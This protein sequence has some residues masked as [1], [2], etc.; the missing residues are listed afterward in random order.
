MPIVAQ[1]KPTRQS[2]KLVTGVFAFPTTVLGM[3]RNYS[4]VD[5]VDVR[6]CV[7]HPVVGKAN[8]RHCEFS[9][10]GN[11]FSI[12]WLSVVGCLLGRMCFQSRY[13]LIPVVAPIQLVQQA[14]VQIRA[15]TS[16]IATGSQL[17]IAV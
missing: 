15:R 2:S 8:C 3:V 12:D 4:G 10:G 6:L 5:V 17:N 16:S 11:R 7:P 13:S 1:S 9:C 14:P